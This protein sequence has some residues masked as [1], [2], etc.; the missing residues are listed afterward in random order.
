MPLF[1]NPPHKRCSFFNCD[2]ITDGR[3]TLASVFKIVRH[4]ATDATQEFCSLTCLEK[5]V[6][7]VFVGFEPKEESFSSVPFG[8]LSVHLVR[9]GQKTK[10]IQTSRRKRN[11]K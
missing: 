3:K 5:H 7:S 10:Q 9:I 8:E 4:D 1:G 2:E 11:A 6:S